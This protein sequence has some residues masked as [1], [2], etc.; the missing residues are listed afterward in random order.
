LP[1]KAIAELMTKLRD[2]DGLPLEYRLPSSWG[3]EFLIL[4]AARTDEVRKAR[5]REIDFE[6]RVWTK[7]GMTKRKGVKD[8]GHTKSGRSHRVPLSGT[9]IELLRSLPWDHDRDLPV[10]QSELTRGGLINH[11]ALYNEAKKHGVDI[12][13]HGFR[14]TFRTW[15]A[16]R[17]TFPREMAEACL[18]HAVGD[19]TEIAYQRDDLLEPRR[20]LMQLWADFCNA[21]YVEATVTDLLVVRGVA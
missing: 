7:P 17:T 16:V 10:F 12:T 9:A 5:W 4:T 11:N 3:L 18:D 19:R 1:Y 2:T 15:A 6:N 13:A 20:P 21:P 14:T 8:N